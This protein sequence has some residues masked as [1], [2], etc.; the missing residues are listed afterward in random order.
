[1]QKVKC[2]AAKVT[3]YPDREQERTLRAGE[4]IYFRY[5]PRGGTEPENYPAVVMFE[6]D[7][8]VSFTVAEII[9]GA[10]RARQGRTK[11]DNVK[12][13]HQAHEL[14]YVAQA[15]LMRLKNHRK[16]NIQKESALSEKRNS[17][18]FR[19]SADSRGRA[20]PGA[21]GVTPSTPQRR[22]RF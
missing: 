3:R 22:G 1:M 7:D 6:H 10:P 19:K 9:D 18:H 5:I 4:L 8:Q 17:E 2:D 13:R 14:D 11:S 12:Q 21:P 20:A 16:M 15:L